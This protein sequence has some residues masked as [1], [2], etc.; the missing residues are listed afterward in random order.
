MTPTPTP[1]NVP[2]A[3]DEVADTYDLMV[4]LS[5]G[6][7]AQLRR[8]AGAL[9]ATV[10]AGRDSA[11]PRPLHLVDLGCGSGASTRALL[12]AVRRAESGAE[13]RVTGVDASAGMLR[14]AQAKEWPSGVEFAQARAEDLDQVPGIGGPG[15]IDGVFAAYLLR[16]VD[17][18]D[19]LLRQIHRLLRPGA[20]LVLH[21]YSV[22]GNRRAELVWTAVCHG[23]IVPLASVVSRRTAIYRYLWRSVMDFD[24]VA[25]VMTRLQR[26][27]FT[28]VRARSFPGWQHG[29]IHTIHG[30]RPL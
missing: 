3:F 6:Y 5:P 19:T 20:P 11:G 16:N 21:E 28:D 25:D 18:R 12:D 30:R 29:I 15:S 13:V 24:S 23:V 4:S 2:E 26:S 9:V 10:L 14:A 27:G 7:H 17:D 8:S 1:A 22:A